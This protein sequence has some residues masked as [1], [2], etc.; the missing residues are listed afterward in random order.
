MTKLR[1]RRATLSLELLLVLP[2]LIMILG[3]TVIFGMMLVAQQVL[4][5]ASREG[6][7]AAAIGDCTDAEPAAMQ[8]LNGKLAAATVDC[9]DTDPVYVSVTV[10][11]PAPAAIPNLLKGFGFG[12]D[13]IILSSTTVMKRE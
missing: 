12:L 5:T 4:T 2:I 1:T 6:A 8:I 13:D 3:G 10:S 9:D 7:R 11:I